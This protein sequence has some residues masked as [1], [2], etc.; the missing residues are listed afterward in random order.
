M[1]FW[2]SR[3]VFVTGATGLLG[4]W[5]VEALL[6]RG[7]TVT[8]LVRDWTPHSR[9]V[10][11][12]FTARANLVRGELEDLPLLLRALNEYEVDTVFHLGAQTIVGTANR[13]PLSTFESN[14]R[15]TWNLLEAWRLNGPG[16]FVRDYFYV[17]DAVGAYLH[18]AER[19][20]AGN[21]AGEA[22]NFSS[23]R[24]LPVMTVVRRILELTGRESLEP[25]ILN[26]SAGEIPNQV[27]DCG[28]AREL[29]GWEPR[30]TMDEGLRETIDWYRA[31][32]GRMAAINA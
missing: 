30:F 20:E 29:L 11:L 24:P 2:Q 14:V 32:L 1:S 13:S 19:F 31:H 23:E 9:F 17:R 3:S 15:G 4:S 16:K 26:Q 28:K 22:F 25:E 5:L 21:V 12:G 27:L 7:A 18:L 10:E 8:C 6:D